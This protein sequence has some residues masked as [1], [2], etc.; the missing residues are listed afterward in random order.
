MKNDSFD[1]LGKF[2]LL[3]CGRVVDVTLSEHALFA[4]GRMLGVPEDRTVERIPLKTIFQ[5]LTPAEASC[6]L[7]DGADPDCVDYLKETFENSL[8]S[9]CPRVDP[10]VYAIQKWNW[11]RTRKKAFYARD[12]CTENQRRLLESKEFWKLQPNASGTSW[13]LLYDL[14][15][16]EIGGTLDALKK[17]IAGA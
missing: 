8:S 10:R 9:A 5:R 15:G 11:I 7:L 17:N 6:A 13:L 3:P 14:D 4:R 16:H 2:W 12:W 1:V